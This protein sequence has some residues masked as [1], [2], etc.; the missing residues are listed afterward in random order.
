MER[1][2]Q[3]I[4]GYEGAILASD[5]EEKFT[6]DELIDILLGRLAEYEDTGYSPNDITGFAGTLEKFSGTVKELQIEIAHIRQAAKFI[7]NSCRPTRNDSG[8]HLDAPYPLGMKFYVLFHGYI[9]E[10]V[11]IG[12]QFRNG[13]AYLISDLG[14]RW[15]IGVDAWLTC[16][17]ARD[18]QNEEIRKNNERR[19]E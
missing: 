13:K 2:T 15:E 7:G 8:F 10:Q 11:V 17:E 1:L 19:G 5:M 12:Y 18:Y 9:E 4:D 6:A 16:K 3:R 14:N